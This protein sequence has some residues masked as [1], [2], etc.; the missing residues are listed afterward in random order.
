MLDK[1]ELE[2]TRK[3]N[4]ADTKIILD[5]Q[6]IEEKIKDLE[7]QLELKKGD[8]DNEQYSHICGKLRVLRAIKKGDL[9]NI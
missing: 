6:V 3:L 7:E 5:I 8:L 1:E 4:G 2:A 9:D